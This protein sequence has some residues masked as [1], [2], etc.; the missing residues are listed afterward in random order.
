ME[1]TNEQIKMAAGRDYT[2]HYQL[3]GYAVT[4][5]HDV[6]LCNHPVVVV[7]DKEFNSYDEAYEFAKQ[8]FLNT[9]F[10][11]PAYKHEI[12]VIAE[13]SWNDDGILTYQGGLYDGCYNA[14]HD[15]FKAKWFNSLEEV[16]IFLKSYCYADGS[17]IKSYTKPYLQKIVDN[18]N[19]LQAIRKTHC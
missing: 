15:I 2:D 6:S 3:F 13:P 19:A 12:W 9:K 11:G 17:M 18:K 10:E 4:Y 7:E 1:R 14:M 8:K 16:F 5:Y